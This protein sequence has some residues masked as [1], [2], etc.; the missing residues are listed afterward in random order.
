MYLRFFSLSALLM[1]CISTSAYELNAS[2][3]R[4][5]TQF[6]RGF[7]IST[8]WGLCVRRGS[9]NSLFDVPRPMLRSSVWR[10]SF[11]MRW[12]T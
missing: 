3:L 12:L 4:L 6:G 11:A 9:K 2:T 5:V 7:V 10:A 1:V 8:V